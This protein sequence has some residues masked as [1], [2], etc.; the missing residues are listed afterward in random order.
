MATPKKT[1]CPLC[2]EQ[3]VMYTKIKL[4]K[5]QSEHTGRTHTHIW[6]CEDCPYVAFEFY[7]SVDVML[8]VKRLFNS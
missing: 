1:K 5:P 8:L 6:I 7:D 4:T 2:E 3:S